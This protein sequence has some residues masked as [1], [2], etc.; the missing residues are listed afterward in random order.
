[1]QIPRGGP[2]I[3]KRVCDI[4]IEQSD[5]RKVP[6]WENNLRTAHL[7][8]TAVAE[9]AAERYEGLYERLRALGRDTLPQ[10]GEEGPESTT[11]RHLFSFYRVEK[12]PIG[13]TLF[14]HSGRLSVMRLLLLTSYRPRVA[15]VVN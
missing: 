15:G 3:K 6:A 4:G 9:H 5:N 11:D 12:V 14:R 1:M 8:R 2:A 10:R 13:G 7:N